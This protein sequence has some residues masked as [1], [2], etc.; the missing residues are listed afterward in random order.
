MQMSYDIKSYLEPL[1]II[2]KQIVNRNV[3]FIECAVRPVKGGQA[4]IERTVG[5]Q[6]VTAFCCNFWIPCIF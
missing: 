4:L 2:L 6:S 5:D 3:H 1:W